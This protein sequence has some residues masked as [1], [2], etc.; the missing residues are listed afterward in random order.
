MRGRRHHRTSGGDT[1]TVP[2]ESTQAMTDRLGAA[3]DLIA[4]AQ[5]RFGA[6]AN[7]ELTL[8]STPAGGEPVEVSYCYRKPGFIRMD[9]IRPHAGATL[10]YS[11]ETGK[12]LLWPFGFHTFPRLALSPD[13]PLIQGPHGHRVDRS[14][15]GA[16]LANVREL[17][18]GGDSHLA[19]DDTIG[20]RRAAH[21]IVTGVPGH[22]AAGVFRYQLWLDA[23]T[24]LPIKVTSDDERGELI[25]T[26][27]MDDLR[28]DV[29]DVKPFE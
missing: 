28:I 12:V 6:L 29:P 25:E 13:H 21:L 20:S 16:L 19:G 7:Y 27:L 17:Q 10:S 26:V 4:D 18:R 3:P 2:A 15:L 8:R 11:P 23:A 5:A 14:D 1:L 24:G 22:V 9:F